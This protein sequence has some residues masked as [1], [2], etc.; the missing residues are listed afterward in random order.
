[1]YREYITPTALVEAFEIIRT[2]RNLEIGRAS[3]I[4]G[5]LAEKRCLDAAEE[6]CKTHDWLLSARSCTKQEDA[7]GIDIVV[8]SDIGFLY[9]QVKSS[10]ICAW[11]FRQ[12]RS[13]S[14]AIVVIIPPEMA[15]E[16]VRDKVFHALCRLRRYFMKIRRGQN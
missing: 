5:A 14:K 3:N 13:R 10:R 4:K 11:S 9:I 7:R 16:K 15:D 12:K 1:M 8:E 2:R 6:L